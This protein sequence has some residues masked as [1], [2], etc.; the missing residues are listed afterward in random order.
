MHR[1]GPRPQPPSPNAGDQRWSF[2]QRRGADEELHSINLA[3]S[4]CGRHRRVSELLSHAQRTAR[5]RRWAAG[6]SSDEA[7]SRPFARSWRSSRKTIHL[8]AGWQ[9]QRS[10]RR[11]SASRHPVLVG[12]PTFGLVRASSARVARGSDVAKHLQ[13]DKRVSPGSMRQSPWSDIEAASQISANRSVTVV[14]DGEERDRRMSRLILRGL[15]AFWV[16][17]LNVHGCFTRDE[18]VSVDHAKEVRAAP[19]GVWDLPQRIDL[20]SPTP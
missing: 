7:T 6:H 19:G 4:S 2:C 9:R 11:C 12:F 10:L 13:S 18:L 1:R 14:D 15:R 20:S 3:R 8:R 5:N 17:W 16:S